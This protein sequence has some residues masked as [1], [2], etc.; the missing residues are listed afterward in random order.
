MPQRQQP[1]RDPALDP[2]IETPVID[3]QDLEHNANA[4]TRVNDSGIKFE[5]LLDE[6]VKAV[7]I[8][9]AK[10][11]EKARKAVEEFEQS[12]KSQPPG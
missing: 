6:L 1:E 8:D 11:D 10:E 12:L 3:I 2:Q 4:A 7:E 9:L 5:P